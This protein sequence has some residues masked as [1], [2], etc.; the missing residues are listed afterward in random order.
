MRLHIESQLHFQR[1]VLGVICGLLPICCILF[2]LIGADTAPLGDEWWYSI[3]ATYFSNSKPLMIGALTLASFFFAT[4]RGYDIEDRLLTTISSITA[5]FIVIFPCD[6]DAFDR[7]G[8]F[9]LPTEISS[10]I[11]NISAGVLFAS[12]AVMILTQFTKGHNKL[13]NRVYYVCGAIILTS[14]GS[15]IVTSIL[16]I[17]WMTIVNEFFMLEAFAVAWIVKSRAISRKYKQ[18]QSGKI[19]N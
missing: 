1:L 9:M 8:L 18:W 11:H 3:S 7:C 14:M 17:E 19:S 6:N 4:Y 16:D 5:A 2:G 10:V 15:Q 12:F 13:R